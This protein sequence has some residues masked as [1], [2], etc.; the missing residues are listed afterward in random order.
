ML[1]CCRHVADILMSVPLNY[2]NSSTLKKEGVLNY[3]ENDFSLMKDI[4]VNNDDGIDYFNSLST[5]MV[6]MESL[7][8]VDRQGVFEE[9]QRQ[10]E[11]SV[12]SE[13]T[14]L[15]CSSHPQHHSCNVH[16]LSSLLTQHRNPSYLPLDNWN[17]GV[18]AH[19]NVRMIPVVRQLVSP[20]TGV[21]NFICYDQWKEG[22]NNGTLQSPDLP[23]SSDDYYDGLHNSPPSSGD[24]F[25]EVRLA[26]ASITD[27]NKEQPI[28]QD[29][30]ANSITC[31]LMSLQE[32]LEEAGC[33]QRSDSSSLGM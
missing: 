21:N 19:H 27:G 3:D 22:M 28:F 10:Q 2:Q 9:R 4:N 14:I 8:E 1:D 11:L 30:N 32:P 26:V 31:K 33:S 7:L 25:A 17:H 23:A 24:D 5:N 20:V 29:R 6:K 18:H 16:F 13:E 15:S 12:S